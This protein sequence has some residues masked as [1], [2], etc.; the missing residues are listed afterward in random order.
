[1]PEQIFKIWILIQ[2]KKILKIL[3]FFCSPI[4]VSTAQIYYVQILKNTA[5]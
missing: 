1:M 5:K 4:F 2:I 3:I